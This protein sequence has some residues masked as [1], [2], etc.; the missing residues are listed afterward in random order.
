MQKT[1]SEVIHIRKLVN[2]VF[3]HNEFSIN[4]DQGDNKDKKYFN[5]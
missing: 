5:V 1:L 2:K 4:A 3:R